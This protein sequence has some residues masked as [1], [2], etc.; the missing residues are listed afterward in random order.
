MTPF[1][2]RRAELGVLR[3]CLDDARGGRPRMVL[4]EGPAGIGKTAL[5]DRLATDCARD[6]AVVVLRASGDENEELLAYG[7]LRQLV[8]SAGPEAPQLVPQANGRPLA[9][10][11]PLADPITVGTG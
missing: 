9:D 1:V 8:R 11:A 5:L 7:L 2:G 10:G 6:P 4:I 3:A